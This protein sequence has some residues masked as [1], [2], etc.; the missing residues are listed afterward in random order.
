M[1]ATCLSGERYDMGMS[2]AEKGSSPLTFTSSC[3]C[4]LA[5]ICLSRL[6]RVLL[7]HG[8]HGVARVKGE[9]HQT[10]PQKQPDNESKL[11]VK[12]VVWKNGR[13]R[14]Q[15]LLI[16]WYARQL[17]THR[18]YCIRSLSIPGASQM[19]AMCLLGERYGHE[20]SRKK[21]QVMSARITIRG[22]INPCLFK[23]K[24]V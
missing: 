9:G 16:A 5:R 1:T 7:K 12:G 15:D 10:P 23:K 22:K 13:K 6:C 11:P 8:V 18:S 24:K 3:E 14:S 20:F 4:A 19:T 2:W 17:F 21:V